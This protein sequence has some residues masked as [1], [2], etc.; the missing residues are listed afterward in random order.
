[1]RLGRKRT[2]VPSGS[3]GAWA[4]AALALLDDVLQ[5]RLRRA[6]LHLPTRRSERDASYFWDRL[7]VLHIGWNKVLILC[8]QLIPV[9]GQVDFLGHEAVFKAAGA[10]Q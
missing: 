1:M 4:S 10:L 7:L 2:Q 5:H 8:L 9:A 3:G 6:A